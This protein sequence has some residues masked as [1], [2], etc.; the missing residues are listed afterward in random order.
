M[1]ENYKVI[2]EL[3]DKIVIFKNRNE[4]FYVKEIIIDETVED[5]SKVF[6]CLECKFIGRLRHGLKIHTSLKHR[7]IVQLDGICDESVRITTV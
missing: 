6:K 7:N 3:S 5:N 1:R 4:T 2:E